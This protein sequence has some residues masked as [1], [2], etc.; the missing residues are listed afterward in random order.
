MQ[1]FLIIGT[2]Q[3]LL[4]NQ[5]NTLYQ[6]YDVLTIDRTILSTDILIEETKSEKLSGGARW[7][8]K[9]S[10]WDCDIESAFQF[11]KLAGNTLRAFAIHGAA[12]HTFSFLKGLRLG[13]E[14]N[15]ASGDK[16]STDNRVQTFDNL[17]PTNHLKYGYLD[18]VSLRN[19]QNF[20]LRSNFK[21]RNNV[22]LFLSLDYWYFLL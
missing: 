4:Q 21:P 18:L 19:A 1:S 2:D 12:H 20:A 9:T 7:H 14:Y 10:I 15:L 5:L 3:D 22:P 8:G 11:G 6:A 17:F 13:A 16:S